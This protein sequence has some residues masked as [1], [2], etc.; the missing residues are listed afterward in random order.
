MRSKLVFGAM[1]QVPNRFLL[2]K[3]AA[4][5][6]REFHRPNT[7][8]QETINEV[9]TRFNRASPIREAQCSNN[10]QAVRSVKRTL[11][12]QAAQMQAVA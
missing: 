4:R 11:S 7:R 12:R 1:E 9:L 3:L 6:T 5:A 8:V 2:A 10:V